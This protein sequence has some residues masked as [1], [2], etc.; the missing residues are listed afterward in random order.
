M[1]IIS[2]PWCILDHLSLLK[3]FC[4]C[5]CNELRVFFK[6]LIRL[7]FKDGWC[8]II[9]KYFLFLIWLLSFKKDT[10][11]TANDVPMIESK[12]HLSRVHHLEKMHYNQTSMKS[13]FHQRIQNFFMTGIR[14]IMPEKVRLF[15]HSYHM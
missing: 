7:C 14:I 8:N 13:P 3:Y 4:S 11:T 10:R 12:M 6:W 1:H 9:I 2:L 15:N 5:H